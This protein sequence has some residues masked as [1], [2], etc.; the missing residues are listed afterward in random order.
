VPVAAYNPGRA[1]KTSRAQ[2]TAPLLE[3]G[4]LLGAGARRTRASRFAGRGPLLE[5][6]E[7]FP[8]GEHDDL[9]DT[10]TQAAIYLRDAEL[11]ELDT[12][13][14]EP[15]EDIDYHERTKRAGNPYF[16]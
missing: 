12:V 16:A 7:Q 13:D 3:C 6:M 2:M 15:P 9:V 11:L 4:L 10:F 5:Q 14:E 1:D 8:N